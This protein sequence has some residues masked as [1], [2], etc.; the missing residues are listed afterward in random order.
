MLLFRPEDATWRKSIEFPALPQATPS[1]FCRLVD[2]VVYWNTMRSFGWTMRFRRLRHERAL[3]EAAEDELELARIGVDVADGED[4]GLGTSRTAPLIDPRCDPRCRFKPPTRHGA[5]LHREAEDRQQPCGGKT[6]I[7]LR[8]LH[9]DCLKDACGSLQAHHLPNLEGEL[10]FLVQSEHLVHAVR[11]GAEL[12]SAVHQ[13]QVLGER[14]QV[15]CPVERG[16]AAADDDEIMLTK[17][18]H[19][20]D[21][22]EDAT[23]LI[24]FDAGDR[25]TLRLDEP[26]PAATTT[27]L[28]AIVVLLSVR[29][30]KPSS[31]RSS[32]V[33]ISPK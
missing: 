14:L 31:V 27:T 22:I 20:A 17:I 11:R 33:T 26:P 25:R 13:C 19:A 10:L 8:S 23:A 15:E 30:R 16:I 7:A 5:E 28:Q 12:G 4:A 9:D 3:V 18:L 1:F 2:D 21:R 24:C 32:S 29:T 6:D